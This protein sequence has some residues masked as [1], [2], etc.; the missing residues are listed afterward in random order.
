MSA[1]LERVVG[2]LTNHFSAGSF[3]SYDW[4]IRTLL[5]VLLVSFVCG[6]VGSLVV[7]N[8]M[9]FFSD[10]LAHCAFAG[11]SLGFLLALVSGARSQQDFL[12][13]LTPSM[14]VFGIVV[15]VAIFWVRERTSL[16]NDTVIGIFF[17]GALGLGSILLPFVSRRRYFNA[18][19]FLFGNPLTVTYADLI[20]LMA[21]ALLTTAL[22]FWMY[23]SFV[24]A[25]FNASLARSRRVPVSL[26]NLAFI[27]LLALVINMSIQT[28][29]ALLINAML[30]VPAATAANLTRNLRQQFWGTVVLCFLVGL[31]GIWVNWNV[32]VFGSES[33]GFGDVTLDVGGVMVCLSVL[34]FGLSMLAGPRVRRWRDRVALATHTPGG[35][36]VPGAAPEPANPSSANL[37]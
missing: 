10:A 6:A 7:G 20:H 16:S 3:F 1:W 12:P 21:L 32:Y 11:V 18:E 19:H 15:G 33:N 23:N 4:N 25:S 2:E 30:V 27:V 31:A 28:V 24:L 8:R 34:L 5:A 37:D 35:D 13:W 17:A 26:C 29:G 14:T 22:L 9:A 36:N